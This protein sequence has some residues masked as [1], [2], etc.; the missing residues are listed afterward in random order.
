M[1]RHGFGTEAEFARAVIAWLRADG[2]TVYQEVEASPGIADIVA[3]RAGQLAVV[4]CKLSL[5]LDVLGQAW[6]WRTWAHQVYT[7]VP[8][9]GGRGRSWDARTFAQNACDTMGLGLLEVYRWSDGAQVQIAVAPKSREPD[10][11]RRGL[12]A[13]LQPEHETF[14][15]AGSP[16]GHRW[17]PFRATERA[18][19]AYVLAHPG[20]SPAAACKAIAHHW[21]GGSPG[22]RVV[23][24]IER[25]VIT[26]LR[27]EI[28][29]RP[30]HRR[31]YR[32]FPTAMVEER[33]RLLT[34]LMR[35]PEPAVPVARPALAPTPAAPAT[36]PTPVSS[37]RSGHLV[38]HRSRAWQRPV[39][40]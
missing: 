26:A 34:L 2:W 24:L 36:A 16:T 14:A 6:R 23:K 32:L 30:M 39:G 4:E 20:V 3:T 18:L 10:V 13:V 12:A 27:V 35:R 37:P 7:A 1:K 11:R 17:T 40:G 38:R 33:A 25:G 8:G 31:T 22:S 29:G 21:K 9:A 15:E 5:N 28:G 19:V